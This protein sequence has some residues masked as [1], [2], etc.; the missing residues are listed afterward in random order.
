MIDNKITIFLKEH[1][2]L[3]FSSCKNNL[4]YSANCFYSFLEEPLRFVIAS[5]EETKH[6]SQALS[7]PNISG[8]IALETKQIGK[9][10]GLQFTAILQEVTLKEKTK[11]FKDHPYALAMNPKLW[12][13][14][15]NY[16]KYT[17]NRLGFGKKIEY[18]DLD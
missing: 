15:I 10:Q 17:D 11:Y 6:L 4:P 5:S 9:I 1:H 14:K 8:T 13:L 12:T 2:V 3:S 7:N 16:L 18:K